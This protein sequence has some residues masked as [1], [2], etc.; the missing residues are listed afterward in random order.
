MGSVR[1]HSRWKAKLAGK[2]ISPPKSILLAFFR[3]SRGPDLPPVRSVLQWIFLD[4]FLE[5][6]RN[7]RLVPRVILPCSN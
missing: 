4:A 1:P 3:L 6:R 5:A 2:I 7:H